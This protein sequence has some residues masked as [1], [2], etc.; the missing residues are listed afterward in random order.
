MRRTVYFL[1][2]IVAYLAFFVTILYAIAFVGNML[3]SKTI[4]GDPQ[5]PTVPA[6]LIDGSLLLLFAV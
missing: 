1:Y 2:G 5:M 4:D 3:V 6:L